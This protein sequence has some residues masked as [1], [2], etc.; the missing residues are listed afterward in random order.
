MPGWL[1]KLVSVVVTGLATV[2]S[3]GYVA[4]HLKNPSAPLHPTV[5][6]TGGGRHLH[7]KP[8]VRA[9]PGQQPLTFTSVS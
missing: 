7:L 9:G 1:L 6:S 8:A 2:A 4:A 5:L 3:A